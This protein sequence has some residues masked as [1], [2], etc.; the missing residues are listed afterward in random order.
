MVRATLVAV[1]NVIV[2][3]VNALMT[4]GAVNEDIVVSWK[5]LLPFNWGYADWATHV[6]K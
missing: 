4:G 6:R 3:L 5:M 1:C 2:D